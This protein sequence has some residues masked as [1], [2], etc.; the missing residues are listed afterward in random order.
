M[1]Q[2]K[3]ILEI[4]LAIAG[5]IFRNRRSKTDDPP[6]PSLSDPPFVGDGGNGSYTCRPGA[7]SYPEQQKAPS[8]V[9]L[10]GWCLV[11]TAASA[12][13]FNNLV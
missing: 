10:L 11:L 9:S 4:V 5:C 1:K 8:A 13:I 7:D 12:W 2:F 3:Q 6:V